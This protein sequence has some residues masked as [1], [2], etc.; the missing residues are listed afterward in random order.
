MPNLQLRF[1]YF[2]VVESRLTYGM[3]AW[4]G[5]S[6]NHLIQLEKTQKYILK[7]I[8]KKTYNPSEE[9]YVESQIMDIRQLFCLK[10]LVKPALWLS[11]NAF[12]LRSRGPGFESWLG[13]EYLVAFFMCYR[14]GSSRL[15]TIV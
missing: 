12:G 3:I 6:H 5:A 10:I 1:L 8:S 9:L 2:A 11:A 7:I 4:G 15:D 13:Y 14:D